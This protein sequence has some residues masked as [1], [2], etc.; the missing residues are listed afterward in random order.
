MDFTYQPV[1][2]YGAIMALLF[3]GYQHSLLFPRCFQKAP[4]FSKGFIMKGRKHCGKMR[5]WW[6]PAF[7]PFPTMFSKGFSVREGGSLKV[8]MYGKGLTIVVS[9]Y[10]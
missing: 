3:E 1:E 4:L 10:L 7:F 2:R 5:K 6:L 9:G 8:R